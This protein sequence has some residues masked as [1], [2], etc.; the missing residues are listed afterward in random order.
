ML[1]ALIVSASA[2]TPV[3]GLD[4]SNKSE[5]ISA[6]FTDGVELRYQVSQS[7]SPE[8]AH[9]SKEMMSKA[10][11][12]ATVSSMFE[13]QKL[14]PLK[15]QCD[16]GNLLEIFEISEKDLNDPSR[17][18]KQYIYD[19]EKGQGPLWGYYDPRPYEDKVD[20]IVISNHGDQQNYRIM[21]HEIAH[22]WYSAYCLERYSSM[23]SEQ[24]ATK[25][26]GESTWP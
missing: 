19:P 7:A 8:T 10:V 4:L 21:V 11:G 12:I 2:Y 20:S 15:Y 24:F 26:A 16:R 23:T 14:T 22:Y 5:V 17:F 13:I 3:D 9:L 18:P 1:L 25:I 6:K